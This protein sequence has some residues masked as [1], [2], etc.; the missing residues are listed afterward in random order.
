MKETII[1]ITAGSKAEAL[2]I[3]RGLVAKKLAA[4]VNI[5]TGVHSI[6]TWKGKTEEAKEVL[7]IVKSKAK[8]FPLIEKTVKKLHSYECPEIISVSIDEGSKNYLLWLQ[9]STM[10]GGL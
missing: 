8:L 10:L 7:L 1:F 2:K 4:C 6:Y 9:E 5:I 3:A